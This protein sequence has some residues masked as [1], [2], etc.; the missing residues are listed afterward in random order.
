VERVMSE[1]KQLERIAQTE[2]TTASLGS[3]RAKL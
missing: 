1:H 3:A 2:A